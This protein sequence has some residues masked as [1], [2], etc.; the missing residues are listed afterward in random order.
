VYSIGVDLGTASV[1]LAVVDTKKVVW[2]RYVLHH[3]NIA[4]T[5]RTSLHVLSEAIPLDKIKCGACIGSGRGILNQGNKLQTVNEVAA[6][7]DGSLFINPHIHSIIDI[8]AQT[9]RF[10]T[11]FSGEDK[12]R[13]RFSM[14]SDCAAGTGAFLEEQVLRLGLE[15]EDYSD[16]IERAACIPRIAGRCSVFAKTDIIHHQQEGAAVED[17][18]LG[19]A[20][21]VA[22][23]YKGT[24]MKK[25]PLH[26]PVFFAGGVAYN[27]GVVKGLLSALD[28]KG[29]ELIVDPRAG[30]AAAVGTAVVAQKTEVGLELKTILEGLCKAKVEKAIPSS[31]QKPLYALGD[32]G[33]EDRHRCAA[34]KDVLSPRTGYLGVDVG[35]TSTNIVVIDENME[36]ISLRYLKTLG[37]PIETVLRGLADIHRELGREVK[38]SSVGVTGSGRYLIGNLIGADVI[39]DEITAQARAAAFLEPEVDTVFEIGGQDSKY[40]SIRKGIVTDFAMN[41]ICAAGTGSFLEEQAKKLQ[42]PIGDFGRL[43]LTGKNPADLGERCTVFI[44]TNVAYHLSKGTPLE[45]IAAGLCY[46]IVRNYLGKVVEQKLV[47]RK[48]LF[49]GG[50]AYNQGVVSALRSIL[51]KDII[52]PDYFSVTG[53]YGVAMLA[54]EEMTSACTRFKGFHVGTSSVSSPIENQRNDK[55][56]T[57]PLAKA[58]ALYLKH[59]DGRIDPSK[60]T[61]GIPRVLFLHKLFPMFNIIFKELGYNVLLSEATQDDIIRHSQTYS[62]EETCY[63]VKLVHGHVA[64]LLEHGVDYIFLPSLYTM[65]HEISRVREDYA[66]TYMQSVSKIIDKTMNLEGRGVVLLSPS[67]AFKFGKKHMLKTLLSLGKKLK[68]SMFQ[69]LRA[70]KLGMDYFKEFE[71][72]L[73]SHGAEMVTSLQPGEKAFVLISRPYNI[74]DPELNMQIPK[75]LAAMGY[76]VLTLSMLPAHRHDLFQEYPNMYWPFGQHILSGAQI[77]KQHP[78]LFAIYLTSHGCGPDTVLTH[79][80][81]EEMKGKPYLHIETDEHASSVGVDTRIEA[82]INSLK[83]FEVPASQLKALKECSEMVAHKKVQIITSLTQLK[84]HSLIGLPYLYPYSLIFAAL[85]GRQGV[86][87]EVLPMTNPAS[88]ARG[89]S[90]TKTKEHLTL[91]AM[92][93]DIFTWVEGMEQKSPISILLPTYEG[94]EV[95]GQYHRLLRAKLDEYGYSEVQVAAPFIEDMLLADT[96]KAETIFCAL[97]AGDILLTAAPSM[98]EQLMEETVRR[99]REKGLSLQDLEEL[100]R[101]TAGMASETERRKRVFA[102]GDPM[103]LHNSFLNDFSLEQMEREAQVS[104]QPIAEYLWFLWKDFSSKGS[105][106]AI[107]K[108]NVLRLEGYIRRVSSMLGSGSPYEKNLHALRSTADQTMGL[109]AGANGR[110]RL[111]KLI[112]VSER[113]H[114]MVAAASMYENTATILSILVKG[115]DEKSLK[116]VLDLSFDGLASETNATK[117]KSFMYFLQQR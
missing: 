9:T 21:A 90:F 117:V 16:Y 19:L 65:K 30:I 31:P 6:V 92:L 63:P 8:G 99:V 61:I 55:K 13:L 81:A 3:G 51:G 43:A 34:P 69:T 33:S 50:L 115:I 108:K 23:N 70:A 107:C 114:G 97:L 38:I 58:E 72:D 77:V 95:D 104:Y 100:A 78:N 22:K 89:R 59:Y 98:R 18:M 11:D 109:Y 56:E 62:I 27:R 66:C 60:K 116:P 44:E 45:D 110:Y 52:V 80:F 20:Y 40:I 112:C 74:A 67:L 64:C 86:K 39:K 36:V 5:L 87:A 93:G 91:T 32:M 4:G 73:E 14:N 2:H 82:F 15:L 37:K 88:L 7:V 103:V 83:P 79:Y 106:P 54:R 42:I 94:S 17:I 29:H 57:K 53:A 101:K 26:Q 96:Q 76:K 105:A 71:K 35:S 10:I 102:I 47:G 49:Q 24:V 85:L 113:S 84:P 68:R 75:K 41:K 12:S 1:K 46:S 28:L 111:A 48:I 25:L